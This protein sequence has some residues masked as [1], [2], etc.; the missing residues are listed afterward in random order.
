MHPEGTTTDGWR[1]P[2]KELERA[3][4]QVIGEFL[5][6]ELRAVERRD[7]SGIERQDQVRAFD[8][9]VPRR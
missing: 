9:R 4:L 1:L 3:V 8:I 2:A 7:C 5:R 6:D